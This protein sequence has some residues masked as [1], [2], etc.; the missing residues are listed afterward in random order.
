[1]R[2]GLPGLAIILSLRVLALADDAEEM[3]ARTEAHGLPRKFQ[4]TCEVKEEYSGLDGSEYKSS[5]RTEYSRN[6]RLWRIDAR[7]VREETGADRN[8]HPIESIVQFIFD[9]SK[10][11]QYQFAPWSGK[12]KIVVSDA[13]ALDQVI[14]SQWLAFLYGHVEGDDR[15]IFEVVRSEPTELTL[16]KERE[17]QG[18]YDCVVLT[19]VNNHGVFT[20][21][22]A[23]E[24]DWNIV[25]FRQEMKGKNAWRDGRLS[26]VAKIPEPLREK[27]PPH[28]LLPRQALSWEVVVE[29]YRKVDGGWM[30]DRAK[31]T[32]ITDHGDG[33]LATGK[34]E[35]VMTAIDLDP[36]FADEHF[37]P[38]FPDDTPAI[39]RSVPQ[40]AY[41]WRQGE[42]VPV[43]DQQ[44]IRQIDRDVEKE[45]DR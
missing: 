22:V 19:A 18:T 14:Q 34:A 10:V 27:L 44:T 6:N 31:Y 29:S 7:S 25:R 3:L 15:T 12:G 28:V 4:L 21:W 41:V 40:I 43:V 45:R 9:Q 33:R 2:V 16:R 36:V 20:I 26:D 17:K 13:A 32:H 35:I 5:H 24:L 23:P 42:L 30:P 1:M 8:R 38:G 37:R 39:D 11:Y